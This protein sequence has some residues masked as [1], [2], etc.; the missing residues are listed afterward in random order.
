MF[1]DCFFFFFVVGVV[2]T[3]FD[4]KHLRHRSVQVVPAW[5]VSRHDRILNPKSGS[6]ISH[7]TFYLVKLVRHGSLLLVVNG[8]QEKPLQILFPEFLEYLLPGCVSITLRA[9]QLLTKKLCFLFCFSV[10][11]CCWINF[12]CNRCNFTGCNK[13]FASAT[14]RKWWRWQGTKW[15]Q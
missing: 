5:T 9:S 1:I 11:G 13:N 6:R 3:K 2:L 15:W 12:Q 10:S 4:S 8:S 14:G 7:A